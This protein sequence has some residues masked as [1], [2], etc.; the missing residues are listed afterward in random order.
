MTDDLLDEC[1]EIT[2]H[3]VR[4]Y[5]HSLTAREL[6]ERLLARIEEWNEI[7]EANGV[8]PV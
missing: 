2:I 5:L 6:S 8:P 4:H 7:A 1:I 3:D